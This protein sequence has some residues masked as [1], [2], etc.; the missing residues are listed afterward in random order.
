[1]L[2]GPVCFR[3][4]GHIGIS[5]IVEE[6]LTMRYESAASDLEAVFPLSDRVH[7]FGF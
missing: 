2:E 5:Q 7:K 3:D 4:A 6:C 1:M